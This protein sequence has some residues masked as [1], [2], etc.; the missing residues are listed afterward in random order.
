M[1]REKRRSTTHD[2]DVLWPLA[3]PFK[4]GTNADARATHAAVNGNYTRALH[5]VQ[6]VYLLRYEFFEGCHLEVATL[7]RLNSIFVSE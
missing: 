5:N 6:Y 2:D 4:Y 7:T 3:P 1:H